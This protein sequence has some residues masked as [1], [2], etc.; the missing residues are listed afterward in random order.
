[1]AVLFSA[2]RGRQTLQRPQDTLRP[3]RGRNESRKI[4]RLIDRVNHRY[5][6]QVI[7]ADGTVVRSVDE[8]L[9]RRCGR[10]AAKWRASARAS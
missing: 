8:P 4:R 7:A 6:E 10:G 5:I 2:R 3:A 9:S 1:M